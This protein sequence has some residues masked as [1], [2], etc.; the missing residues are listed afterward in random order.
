MSKP[1]DNGSAREAAAFERLEVAVGRLVEALE[2]A[3]ER[4]DE[5]EARIEEVE[6]RNSE[7]AQM[8]E[9]FTESPGDAQEIMGRLK[10]LETENEDLRLRIDRGREGVERMIARIHF[11]ENQ[12]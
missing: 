5:A 1:E 12:G 2:Q 4:V 9:R 7:M 3:Q 8:V 11:L 6:A 10:T